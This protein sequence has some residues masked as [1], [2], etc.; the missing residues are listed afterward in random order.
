[1]TQRILDTDRLRL[2]PLRDADLANMQEYLQD[3]DVAAAVSLL[4]FPPAEDD[5]RAYFDLMRDFPP[6][7]GGYWAI[8]GKAQGTMI[9]VIGVQY[10]SE[11]AKWAQAQGE[12]GFWLAHNCWG[13]GYM[14]EALHR[15]MM[16]LR[17]HGGVV[18]LV[19]TVALEN[20][21]AGRLLVEAG[22]E[23]G[24]VFEMYHQQKKQV[25]KRRLYH[26]RGDV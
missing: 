9:G 8:E 17:D 2:R 12:V 7:K 13:Q 10:Q 14:Y 15:L 1:M 6:E 21:R 18:D 11:S 5:V 4:P 23:G 22:F 19:A 3:G 25:Q 26:H 24:E 20:D 16:Y